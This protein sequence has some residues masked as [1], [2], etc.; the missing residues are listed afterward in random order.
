MMASSP[1]RYQVVKL[2]TDSFL[3]I[4]PP[5]LSICAVGAV[6]VVLQKYEYEYSITPLVTFGGMFVFV[7]VPHI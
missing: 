1:L 3:Y 6:V 4:G 5:S 2:T 7:S